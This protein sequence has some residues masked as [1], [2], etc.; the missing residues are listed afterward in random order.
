MVKFML[1]CFV[2]SSCLFVGVIIG[3]QQANEGMLKMKGYRD[4]ELESVVQIENEQNG[5]VEASVLGNTVTSQDLQKK[6]EQLER[7]EAFNFFSEL[8]KQLSNFV[9]HI[10]STAIESFTKLIN[11]WL[12]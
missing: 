7:I 11:E 9:S 1:K 8:G 12:A 10:V 5:E 2:L 3:M 4:T 6:Q